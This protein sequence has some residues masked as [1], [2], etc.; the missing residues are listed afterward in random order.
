MNFAVLAVFPFILPAAVSSRNVTI[1]IDPSVPQCVSQF[2]AGVTH[3][4]GFWE[5][6]N[7]ETVERARG[8]LID[9][10][11]FQNQHIMGWGAGNPEPQP[12]V[13]YWNDLDHRVD[14]MRS[15][16]DFAG[17]CA[18]VAGRY[19]DVEYFQVWNEMKGYWSTSLNNH[20]DRKPG[21]GCVELLAGPSDRGGFHLLRL[22]PGR[23]SRSQY[24]H[25]TRADETDEAF[26]PHRPIRIFQ[27]KTPNE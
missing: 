1:E 13:F 21:L 5:Y 23:L 16:G 14:L 15:I 26:R 7:P 9:G 12:G 10:A 2:R 17:L 20:A 27:N 3:T 11:A 8:L 4:H 18:A 24:V 25:E 19:P 22:R 6:G